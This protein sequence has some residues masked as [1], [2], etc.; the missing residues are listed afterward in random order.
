[1]SGEARPVA[2]APRRWLA[3]EMLGRLA[4]Y[5]RFLG[6]DTSYVRGLDDREV[7][8]LAEEERRI[9]VT[10]DRALARRARGAK[11]LTSGHL[12]NQLRELFLAFPDLPRTVRFDRCPECNA[13]LERWP[14]PASSDAW[15][16]ELPKSRVLAGLD[17]WACT[18][19][20]RRYWDGSHATRIRSVV[21]QAAGGIPT[22]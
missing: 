9:L 11:L 10:R 18:P 21:A 17:V 15:P 4:R 12:P 5:L 22:P 1:M 6:E 8:R 2:P 14:V 19:C 3:D 16:A 7:A 13:L 20:S